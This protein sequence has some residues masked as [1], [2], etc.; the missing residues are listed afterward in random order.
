MHIRLAQFYD[1]RL[2]SVETSYGTRERMEKL[3]FESK[4][5]SFIPLCYV[6][7][8]LYLPNFVRF[9]IDLVVEN[10]C[11]SEPYEA[12][13][14]IW[15]MKNCL[16]G[17]RRRFGGG[18][19][20][21][22]VSHFIDASQGPSFRHFSPGHPTLCAVIWLFIYFLWYIREERERERK[23]AKKTNDSPIQVTGTPTVPG[24][25]S[26][27]EVNDCR[28]PWKA[29]SEWWWRIQCRRRRQ[30]MDPSTP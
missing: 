9:L 8:S 3:T 6:L 27:N 26:W 10:Y 13:I 7:R 18:C 1:I 21:S 19:V 29:P 22:S 23:R 28:R 17:M 15:F 30:T 12:A 16:A 20:I 14:S 4:T 11:W 24:N 25:C 2:K 5:V